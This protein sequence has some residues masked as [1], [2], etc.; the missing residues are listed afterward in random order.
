MGDR[1]YL[2]RSLSNAALTAAWTLTKVQ[3]SGPVG[4][5]LGFRRHKPSGAKGHYVLFIRVANG[6]AE[7]IQS[8][9]VQGLKR[10]RRKRITDL[11]HQAIAYATL[12]GTLEG[13]PEQEE[14]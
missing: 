1:L 13:F 14:I 11:A 6:R 2:D 4:V 10:D 5:W 8:G 12:M 7:I 9:R 3:D